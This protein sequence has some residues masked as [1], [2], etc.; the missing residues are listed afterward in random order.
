MKLSKEQQ[1]Q[2][3]KHF[4]ENLKDI[5]ENDLDYAINKGKDKFEK[6]VKN[7][8]SVLA[9]MWEDVKL[10]MSLIIDYKNGVYKEVPWKVIASIVGAV[11]YLIMPIDII[12]DFIP[13]AGY[14]DDAFILKLALD[15]AKDDLERYKQWKEQYNG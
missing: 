6:L 3:R 7:L 11:I 13:V 2:A 4:E 9:Q 15:F 5:D 10:M 1:E 8:P 14:M 12:P